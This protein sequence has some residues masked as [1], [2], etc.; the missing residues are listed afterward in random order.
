MRVACELCAEVAAATLRAAADGTVA[1]TCGACGG[2]F[3]APLA[4]SPPDPTRTDEPVAAT[5]A[6]PAGPLCPKCEAP[7][8][9]DG[10]CPRCGLAPAHADAWRRRHAEPPTATIGAAWDAVQ[11]A[12]SDEAVHERAASIAIAG[13]EL[14]WLAARYRAVLRDRPGDAAARRQLDRLSRRA[15]ATLRATASAGEVGLGRASPRLPIAVLL[16]IV[17][18]VGGGLLYALHV[19]RERRDA[20]ETRRARPAERIAPLPSQR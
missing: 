3:T 1:V 5:A 2:T 16:V 11:A 9:P 18:V 15:E 6:A 4:A 14:A 17:L 20:V 10:P 12:W 19:I 7:A 13:G 8:A